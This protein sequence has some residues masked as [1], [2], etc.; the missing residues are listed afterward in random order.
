[1]KKIMLFVLVLYFWSL[2]NISQW[3]DTEIKEETSLKTETTINRDTTTNDQPEDWDYWFAFCNDEDTPK[4]RLDIMTSPWEKNELCLYFYN[5]TSK[6]IKVKA[7][8]VNWIINNK[9][10]ESCATETD[11]FGSYIQKSRDE[12]VVIP[13]NSHIVKKATLT[14]PIHIQGKNHWCLATTIQNDEDTKWEGSMFNVV[15]RKAYLIRAFVWTMDIE[16]KNQ[17]L[18]NNV[19][20]KKWEDE[21]IIVSWDVI[22]NGIMDSQ[23]D[24]HWEVTNMF[25]FS[26]T[27][28]VTWTTLNV[29]AKK[30]FTSLISNKIQLPK[31]KGLYDIKLTMNWNP[32]IANFDMSK[33][34]IDP[35][36]LEW[37]TV[38]VNKSYF[39]MPRTYVW[40]A[41]LLIILLF[42]AFRK[43]KPAQV[44]YVQQPQQPMP[45]VQ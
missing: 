5:N 21:D 36:L 26:Q 10:K 8:F 13:A 14:F 23:F 43:K 34:D 9:G 1:M 18:I 12:M 7:E 3:Q 25:W 32:Y 35:T 22:N 24:V 16:W 31:Y 33:L 42:F 44:V 29:W 20:T 38:I 11:I 6:D 28:E 2:L 40:W 15:F 41:I 17:T 4:S 19:N 45:P 37:D 30:W 39:E 27:F